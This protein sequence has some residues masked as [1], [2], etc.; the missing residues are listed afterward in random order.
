MH[1]LACANDLR[2]AG[3]VEFNNVVLG[4]KVCELFASQACFAG[5]EVSEVFV[6]KAVARVPLFNLLGESCSLSIDGMCV[7][8]RPCPAESTSLQSHETPLDID[9]SKRKFHLLDR[10][11][12]I[13]GSNLMVSLSDIHFCSAGTSLNTEST[14]V[15][16]SIKSVQT[17]AVDFQGFSYHSSKSFCLPEREV[18]YF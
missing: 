13:V 7:L 4:P 12:A 17:K 3:E 1:L 2:L 15:Y 5:F 10:F 18:R 14:A 8:I 9:N 16:C 11:K 6:R